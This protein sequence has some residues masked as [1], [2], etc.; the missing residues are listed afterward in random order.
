[1]VDITAKLDKIFDLIN[2]KH[3]F[4]IN[5]ARQYGKTT[6]LFRIAKTLPDCYTCI[7]LSFE[8]VGETMFESPEAF[9]QRFLLRVSKALERSDKAFAA[10]WLDTSVT[11]FDLLGYHIDDLCRDRKIVLLIDEIDQ[12]SN[13]RVFLHFLGMLRNKYLQRAGGLVNTFHSVILAG[14]YDIK[15]IKLKL[16]N[17]GVYEQT[18]GRLYNSPWNIAASFDVDMSFGPADIA[19]MLSEY[20]DDH[21]TGMDV[22][23]VS[24]ELFALSGGYPFL[25]SR[26]A[27]CIDE[28]IRP[29][30][31]TASGVQDAAKA[32]LAEKNTLFD[33]LSKNLENNKE[34]Y[35]FLYDVLIV[36]E[37]KTF[38]LSVPVIDWCSMFGY[39]ASSNKDN[40]T[41]G[42]RYAVISNRIFELFM[43]GYF[44]SKDANASRMENAV[45]HTTYQEITKGGRF[46]MELA[47]RKFAEH[48]K[49][50]YS[51]ADAP[52]LE[53]HGR[54]VF[55]SFLRPLING[56]GFYHIESQFTDLRRMD[57]VVDFGHEQFIVELK[58]WKG[59][60]GREKAYEQLLGYMDSKN[61][62]KG[63]LVTFDF[64]KA[65]NKTQF[66]EWVTVGGKEI[67]EIRV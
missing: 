38:A 26:I 64:R 66:A 21:K 36:G 7:N 19:S 52:F 5:R 46:N 57:I 50:M 42:Q 14:V 58:L 16:I 4:T 44:V 61:A 53:R 11:D 1:M 67:F 34:I 23:V 20:E 9:C 45:C 39:I 24:N 22:D 12:S 13:N 37:R 43:G 63:Y 10:Q 29:Q 59:E 54:L 62:G 35:D 3:Y 40:G 33:D 48:Y 27:K 55:L 6:V 25:V 2:Q 49:E 18:N 47:L 15:N 17:E 41:P 65:E 32:V 30:N 28:E 51:G 60:A 8:G 56:Q 31:W